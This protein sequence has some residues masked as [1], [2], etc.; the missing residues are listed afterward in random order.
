MRKMGQALEEE[1]LHKR[2]WVGDK[3]VMVKIY[4]I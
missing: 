4:K 2:E 1:I 3:E